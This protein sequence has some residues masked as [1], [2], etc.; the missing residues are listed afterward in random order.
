[1]ASASLIVD[2][3]I[4]NVKQKKSIGSEKA[5]F[6]NKSTASEQVYVIHISISLKG[7]RYFPVLVPYTGMSLLLK[8]PPGSSHRF[9]IRRL[10]FHI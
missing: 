2:A 10:D 1:M 7:R 3:G 8:G 5:Q 4:W 6:Q 9:L